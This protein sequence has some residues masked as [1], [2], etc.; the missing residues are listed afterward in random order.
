MDLILPGKPLTKLPDNHPMLTDRFRG[1][2]VRKLKIID[3]TLA[4]DKIVAGQREVTP[5]L[6]VVQMGDL[7][8]VV[9]SPLDMSCAL[10]SRHSLQ[11]RGYLREDAARLGINIILFGLQQ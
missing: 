5:Q 6:E 7:I 4:G 8:S 9:F 1:Y 10:E 11:C 3:P 2:D